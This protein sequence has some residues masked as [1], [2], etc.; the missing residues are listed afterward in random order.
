MLIGLLD[1]D[2]CAP[3]YVIRLW[4][5]CQNRRQWRFD[6]VSPEAL[7]AL[8]R[9][10]GHANKLDTSLAASGFIRREADTLTV[11]GWDD[12]NASL[13]ASWTNGLKGGR[14][15]K[16]DE[17]PT[18]LDGLNVGLNVGKP[19]GSREEKKGE[20]KTRL[21][22]PDPPFAS[23]AFKTAWEEWVQHRHEKGVKLTPL[24]VKKQWKKLAAMGEARAIAA[25]EHS[26]ANSYQGIFEPRTN[27]KVATSRVL[28]NGDETKRRLAEMREYE[29]KAAAETKAQLLGGIFKPVPEK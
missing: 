14:P 15:P 21:K 12:Y 28:P 17:K 11:C 27:G 16:A 4:A 6:N 3:V 13:V 1:G 24:A 2:E 20:E 22:P 7:K 5:H 26:I 29:A 10:P 23:E 25:I 9:F 8:C 18:G 19:A